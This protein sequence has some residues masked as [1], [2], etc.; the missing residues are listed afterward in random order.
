MLFAG[1]YSEYFDVLLLENK[2]FCCWCENQNYQTECVIGHCV[3][4]FTYSAI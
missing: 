1:C 4:V 2:L 3:V